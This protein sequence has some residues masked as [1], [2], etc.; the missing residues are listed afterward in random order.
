[1]ER[2][3]EEEEMEVEEVGV[4]E[5]EE[6]E[7]QFDGNLENKNDEPGKREEEGDEEEAG[8]KEERDEKGEES[9]EEE[10]KK[11]EPAK[12]GEGVQEIE[13]V[14]EEAEEEIG[15]V[16]DGESC[17]LDMDC[18]SFTENLELCDG[19]SE[20][21][22]E[23]SIEKYENEEYNEN[24]REY[25]FRELE[26]NTAQLGEGNDGEDAVGDE[27][28]AGGEREVSV[29]GTESVKEDAFYEGE[30]RQA[31][32]DRVRKAPFAQR[33][34]TDPVQYYEEIRGNINPELTREMS[35]VLEENE[36]SRYQGEYKTGRRLNMKRIVGY[37]AS[38]GERNRIW[39]RRTKPSGRKYNLRI[40]V[41]DSGSIKNSGLVEPIVKSLSLI[42]NSL[43]MLGVDFDLYR[44]GRQEERYASLEGLV[45]GLRFSETE[46]RIGW[47][48]SEEY[49][50]GYN[51]IIGDGLFYDASRLEFPLANTLLLV[52]G[53]ENKIKEMRSVKVA[54][55]E[56]LVGK[57]L[58][59]IG[60]M[61]YCIVEEKDLLEVVFTRALKEMLQG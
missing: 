29:E 56:V 47:V 32:E 6:R 35:V 22:V 41:D 25:E 39:M 7:D 10:D 55:G 11:E 21:D 16:E 57:Y 33:R 61:K 44:F 1:V 34:L 51:I 37:L 2:G 20:S 42:A 48:F 46:T 17:E 54:G 52:V 60:V 15:K 9:R 38:E 36:K 27:R 53:G 8:S 43:L 23:I 49:S 4:G 58:D 13:E 30:V 12:M 31:V 18:S 19:G 24:I 14:S 59:G 26:I 28:G 3:G 45:S 5:V 50:D 40:F